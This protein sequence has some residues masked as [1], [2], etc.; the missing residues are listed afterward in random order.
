M[1][2][3]NPRLF[4][5]QFLAS[6]NHIADWLGLTLNAGFE[7]GLVGV[8]GQISASLIPISGIAIK[9]G[10]FPIYGTTVK[11][12]EAADAKTI[13]AYVDDAISGLNIGN[14]AT[15]QY[16]DEQDDLHLVSANA[17]TNEKIAEIQSQVD[18]VKQ[19]NV[20]AGDYIN[21]ATETTVNADGITTETF[22]VSLDEPTLSGH[23]KD[24]LQVVKLGAAS[25]EAFVST[26]ELQLHGERL[27]AQINI[28]KDQFLNNASYV[29]SA[30]VLRLEFALPK[31][32]TNIVD[33]PVGELVDEYSAGNGIAISDDVPGRN[34]IS[35]KRDGESEEFFYVDPTNGVGVSGIQ[36]AITGA[37]ADGFN[38]HRG[39]WTYTGVAPIKVEGTEISLNV[40]DGLV[41]GETLKVKVS[42]AEYADDFFFVDETGAG[43]SGIQA[44]ID[45]A[46]DYADAL[47]YAQIRVWE[48][49]EPITVEE[50]PE[51]DTLYYTD[52]GQTFI[53]K[54]GTTDVIDISQEYINAGTEITSGAAEL[55]TGKAVYEFVAT[56]AAKKLNVIA[57]GTENN[58]VFVGADGQVKDSGYSVQTTALSGSAEATAI[59]VASVVKDYVDAEVSKAVAGD[60]AGLL[61]GK[62]DKSSVISGIVETGADDA[63]IPSEKAVVDFVNAKTSETVEVVNEKAVEM[64][65][66]SVDFGETEGVVTEGT[67]SGRVIAVYDADNEQVYPTIKFADGVSKLTADAAVAT[68]TVIYAKR[69]GQVNGVLPAYQA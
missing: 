28:P 60:V 43:V 24:G 17:Y 67:V 42:E 59:P 36:A 63:S 7:N 55:T 44:A 12:D 68:Y 3:N 65:E 21:V 9:D 2:I 46:K 40:G 33:I 64:I 66:T 50:A 62:V 29:P 57:N 1:R 32:E 26:Y 54:A 4:N 37:V 6:Q 34:V 53:V 51:K 31:G 10:K 23:L 48:G 49:D 27:G 41:S 61:I 16:V 25:D 39:E 30:E 20:V 11:I 69:I 52:A 14:Y 38:D 19:Y 8:S 5:G 58:V 13:K 45:D 35:V 22:T 15:I 56:E 47:P 18:A